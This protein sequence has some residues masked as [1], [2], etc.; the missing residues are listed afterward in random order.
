MQARDWRIMVASAVVFT[1][2]RPLSLARAP[3][4]LA[5]NRPLLCCNP[6]RAVTAILGLSYWEFFFAIHLFK[7]VTMFPAL[8]NVVKAVIVPRR[9]LGLTFLLFMICIFT[10]CRRRA[11]R[12][13]E[14]A[15]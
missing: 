5:P 1:C 9:Q 3:W 4:P 12:P 7:A 10:V 14:R 8:T 13:I 15:C 6:I 11:R 2:S